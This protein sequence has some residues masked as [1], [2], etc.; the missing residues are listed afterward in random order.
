M[1]KDLERIEKEK[2][3][4]DSER[5]SSRLIPRRSIRSSTNEL[6]LQKNSSYAVK[7]SSFAGQELERN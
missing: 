2:Q 1:K 7:W 3:T 4:A 6:Y 5:T